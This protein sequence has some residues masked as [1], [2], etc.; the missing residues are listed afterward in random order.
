MDLGGSKKAAES[1][2][3]ILSTRMMSLIIQQFLNRHNFLIGHLRKLVLK[4]RM[5]V[6]LP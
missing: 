6:R 5:M 2:A 3:Q 1:A 4:N